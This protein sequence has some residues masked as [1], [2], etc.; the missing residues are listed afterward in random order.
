[1]AADTGSMRIT[2][3]PAKRAITLKNR[4]LDL[5]VDAAKVFAGRTATF[6]DDRFDYGERRMIT[7][8]WLDERM[9]VMVWTQRGEVRRVISMRYCHAKEERRFRKQFDAARGKVAGQGEVD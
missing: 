4:G 1:M 8:G 7:A 6:E 9:V 2:S 5:E 3:D